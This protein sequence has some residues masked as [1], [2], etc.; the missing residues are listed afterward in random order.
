MAAENGSRWEKVSFG[1]ILKIGGIVVVLAGMYFRIE[2]L[3]RDRDRDRE[4][5]ASEV[6]R[7]EGR[8]DRKDARLEEA[9]ADE[10]Y[11]DR[12]H[13]MELQIQR[14]ECKSPTGC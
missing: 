14:L 9:I 10:D 8:S 11:G 3:E 7:I 5:F 12:I 1:D 6:A 4:H 2:V 13:T